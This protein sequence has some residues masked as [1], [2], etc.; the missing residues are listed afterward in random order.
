MR[1]LAV[2]NEFLDDV[3]AQLISYMTLAAVG[4]EFEGAPVGC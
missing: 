1:N 4:I 3:E 2:Q